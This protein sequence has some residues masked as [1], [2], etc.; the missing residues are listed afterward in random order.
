MKINVVFKSRS[1]L[2]Q[3]EVLASV[4]AL[5]KSEITSAW[6]NFAKTRFEKHK[7]FKFIKIAPV[8]RS[9]LR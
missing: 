3:K 7:D 2:I 4:I 8:M 9:A 5:N 6:L 1:F